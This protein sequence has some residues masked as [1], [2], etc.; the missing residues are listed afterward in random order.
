MRNFKKFL[1]LVL[2]MLM[3]SACAVSVSGAF[4]DQAAVDASVNAKAIATLTDLGVINGKGLGDGT[5]KYDPEGNLTREEAAAI[6]ARM[7]AGSKV[8]DWNSITTCPFADVVDKWSFGYISYVADRGVME[9][10][11]KGFEP[12]K[13]LTVAEAVAM[14]VKMLGLKAEVAALDKASAPSPWYINYIDVAEQYNLLDKIDVFSYAQSCT[15]AEMA[16]I[17]YN[18]I[19]ATKAD[20]TNK[21]GAGFN[22]QTKT[23]KVTSVADSK[24]FVDAELIAGINY[25]DEAAMN[26]ALTAAGYTM[27]AVDLKGVSITATYNKG[28]IYSVNVN[29]DVK[30]FD[31]T[32]AILSVVTKDGKNTDNVV[33]DGVTYIAGSGSTTLDNGG[34]VGAGSTSKAGIAISIK[35]AAN[36]A[37]AAYVAKANLPEY[38]KATA[39][40]DNKDG[41]YDRIVMDVYSFGTIKANSADAETVNDVKYTFDTITDLVSG[42]AFTNK[43]SDKANYK[44][45]TYIGFEAVKDNTTPVLYR[46]TT[47]DDGK[48]WIVEVLENAKTVTGKLTAVSTAAKYV[49]VDSVKYAFAF[50]GVTVT[51]GENWTLNQTVSIYTI[52]GKFVA[53]AT[54]A[55]KAAVEVAVENVTVEGGKAV[56]T[57]YDVKN[58]FADISITVDGIVDAAGKLVPKTSYS[59]TIDGKA[60]IRPVTINDK[61]SDG[62]VTATYATFEDGA[63]YSFVKTT[64]GIYFEK[65]TGKTIE[66]YANGSETTSTL[67]VNSSYV[68]V[69]TTPKYY[70]KNAVIITPVYVDKTADKYNEYADSYAKTVS[71]A[72]ADGVVYKL[73]VVDTNK[74]DFILVA[75][76]GT[77]EGTTITSVTSIVMIKGAAFEYGYDFNTY[78]AI[79]VMSGKAVD[80][81]SAGVLAD[82]G[83]YTVTDGVVSDFET[84]ALWMAKKDIEV[85][86]NGVLTTIKA[87]PVKLFK[88]ATTGATWEVKHAST[89]T[90]EYGVGNITFYNVDADGYIALDNGNAKKVDVSKLTSGSY[91]SYIISGKMIV[92]ANAT[93]G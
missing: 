21:I 87:M 5:T 69:G 23:V 76:K 8:I 22:F 78:H 11:G 92:I 52:G 4:V 77:G 10:T 37:A 48:T 71:L 31:Y 42:T 20:F 57:G 61:K 56:I 93:I 59:E 70:N 89:N 27:K 41:K 40:D 33:F 91:A 39:F 35:G 55:S 45:I 16:Q 25:F 36:G 60:Y 79:D 80:V 38:Y 24:V 32:D 26:E 88:A 34:A 2:A 14:C 43:T 17:A 49:T 1:A 64:D 86:E 65:A 50:D 51:A 7:V 73:N 47:S 62:T 84:G 29:S 3:V 74:V 68:Y 9:G 12:K 58:G 85:K 63:I 81:K 72:K 30:V 19:V 67:T 44:N 28:T 46:Y 18:T 6:A 90:V 13:T 15:R 75:N 54:A 66:T 82:K 83:F 53:V